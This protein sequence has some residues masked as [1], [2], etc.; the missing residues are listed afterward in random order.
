MESGARLSYVFYH[1][2][3]LLCPAPDM[4]HCASLARCLA[5][6]P[7]SQGHLR[8]SYCAQVTPGTAISLTK[9][10]QQ[11]MDQLEMLWAAEL[12]DLR[13]PMDS[14]L[15][16]LLR[17]GGQ[18]IAETAI[19]ATG[20]KA[21]WLRRNGDPFTADLARSYCAGAALKMVSG[22]QRGRTNG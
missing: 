12:P 9:S 8:A 13:L 14:W 4:S 5:G 7:G 1:C 19:L 6:L 21:R 11:A 17:Q 10:E 3:H 2:S 15:H 18:D 20:K 16:G 22:A